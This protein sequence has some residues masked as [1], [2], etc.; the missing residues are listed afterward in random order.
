MDQSVSAIEDATRLANQSGEAVRE[1]MGGVE[2]RFEELR[3]VVDGW[4][5][6]RQKQS[7]APIAAW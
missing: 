5:D 3:K 6:L 4:V 2:E 7:E 1:R